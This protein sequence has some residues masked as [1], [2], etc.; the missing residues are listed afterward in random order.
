MAASKAA[1]RRSH[2]RRGTS[3]QLGR[4]DAS[5]LRAAIFARS[6][7]SPAR[8]QVMDQAIG[9]WTRRDA[10]G[11]ES[12]SIIRITP[13]HGLGSFWLAGWLF[14]IGFAKLVWWKALLGLVVWPMFLGVA[15]R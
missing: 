11:K 1:A 14:T 7:R 8:R 4:I 13:A 9:E 10:A 6:S 2:M 15:L 3:T 5:R 12:R